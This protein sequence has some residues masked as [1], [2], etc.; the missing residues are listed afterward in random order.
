MDIDSVLTALAL[1]NATVN[2]DSYVGLN[3]NFNI[4]RRPS[5]KRWVWIVWDPS[6]AFGASA[7][8]VALT[9]AL[10]ERAHEVE[11]LRLLLHTCRAKLTAEKQIASRKQTEKQERST[12]NV[13]V[14]QLGLQVQVLQRR[15]QQEQRLQQWG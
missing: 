9:T 5:D 15:L 11:R 10:E 7:A 8:T 12:T 4:Y 1:D 6:L 3:Q 13:A 14:K 2:L